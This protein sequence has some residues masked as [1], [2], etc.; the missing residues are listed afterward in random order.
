[1]YRIVV[2]D[3]DE[4][5]LRTSDKRVSARDRAAIQAVRKLGVKFVPAS[6]RGYRS[7][8]KTLRELD[9][10]DRADEYVVSFNGGAITENRGERL[11]HFAGLPFSLAEEFY[12]RG[13]SYDVC[14]HVYTKDTVYVYNFV[15]GERTFLLG[16]M[17]VE[18]IFHRSLDFLRGEEIVKVLYMNTDHAYLQQI[19]RELEDITG[20]T[21]VSYSSN[22]YLEFNRKGVNKGA[23]LRRLAEILDVDMADTIAI[24][25]NYND[26]SMI[27]AAGIGVGVANTVEELKPECDYVT[28]AT[29]DESAVAEVL[30]RFILQPAGIPLLEAGSL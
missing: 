11:L 2:S 6:G 20:E 3:L 28:T 16:R 7:I 26:L 13:L 9:L 12:R 30:D 4:T 21:D 14:I 1:M 19:A 23:G 25:D 15:E 5:L 17:E 22:R 27:R 24:G 8:E 10:L 18:E 29:C